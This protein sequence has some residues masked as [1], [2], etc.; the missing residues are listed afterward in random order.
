MLYPT[1][2]AYIP[3]DEIDL[4]LAAPEELFLAPDGFLY[5]AD[6]G[7]GRIVK[8]DKDFQ[9]AAEF[10]KGLLKAPTGLF[11]DEDGVFYIAD[12]GKNT[13][14]ILNPDGSLRAEFGR[15]AEP[16]FGKRREF[17]PRKLIVDARKNL[18]IVS[19]GSV[20]GLVMMNTNGN[21]IGYF[22]ANQAQMSLK[23]I[24]QRMF[25]T[26]EQLEQF[27]KTEAASP[28]NLA[29]DRQSLIYTVTADAPTGSAASASSTSLASTC[30]RASS[31]S[32]TFRDL[33]VS[34]DGLLA[35]VDADGKIYE[36]TANG[37][38]A[39]RLWRQRYRR[40][41]AGD[42]G[43][44]RLHRRRAGDELYVL[45]KDKNAILIYRATAFASR[46]HEGVRLYM[47][48]FYVE[49]RPYFEDVLTYNGLFP[50]SY[51][52]IAD[53]CYKQNDYPGALQA[54]P[55][56]RR[57][58][59]LLRNLLGTPQ[60]RLAAISRQ[61]APGLLR[62]VGGFCRLHPPGKT[63]LAGWSPLRESAATAKHPP[64]G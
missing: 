10:G 54:S 56:R 52:G 37:I 12:A 53:A 50:M 41:A 64:G 62:P 8:L 19:E 5:I 57:P 61:R 48:G 27:V 4:P 33:H 44:P 24:L 35:A 40:P 31:S 38:V 21:F 29:I 55:H 11:I 15:P 34:G 63:P 14:V 2:D 1:Q 13:I 6:T 59:R 32:S 51:Q 30:W 46:V 39:V 20:D 36:Y 25:L 60:R 23:M 49:A 42:A 47:D 7:N 18:Y 58:Q 26:R 9:I 43:K 22:G 45:D 28:S 17:L 16:L 3:R